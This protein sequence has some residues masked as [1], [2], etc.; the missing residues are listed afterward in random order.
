MIMYSFF[1]TDINRTWNIFPSEA[2]RIAE[3]FLK[4]SMKL[5]KLVSL[6]DSNNVD[7]LRRTI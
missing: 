4:L 3:T 7:E 1:P 2:A 5:S 6:D